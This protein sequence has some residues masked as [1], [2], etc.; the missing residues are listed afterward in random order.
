MRK[1]TVRPATGPECVK[2][3]PYE[4]TIS[5]VVDNQ[6]M[7]EA[8]V[9]PRRTSKRVDDIAAKRFCKKW[10]IPFPE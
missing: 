3:G 10:K 5:W 7:G 9:K 8:K 4:Y 1:K 2:H 6:V